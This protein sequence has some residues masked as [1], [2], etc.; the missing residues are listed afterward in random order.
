[1]CGLVMCISLA[2]KGA[3][4]FTR[5]LYDDLKQK[6]G[7]GA[8]VKL[9]NQAYKHLQFLS[10]IHRVWNGKHIWPVPLTTS[11]VTDA[12]DIGWGAQAADGQQA[13]GFWSQSTRN[14]H[15]MTRECYAVYYGLVTFKEQ[16]ANQV[17]DVVCDNS[18]VVHSLRVFSTRSQ[19]LM[20]VIG[21][22]FW[23]C[24]RHN[25]TMVPRLIASASN[26]VDTLSRRN[27]DGEWQVASWLFSWLQQQY[28]PHD[29]DR[30]ASH[31]TAM[32]PRYNSLF[33]DPTTEAVDA[34]AQDWGSDNNYA[35]P[36][37]SLV[38]RVVKKISRYRSVKCTLIVPDWPSKPW[39]L[40]LML[41]AKGVHVLPAGTLAFQRL[42]PKGEVV[43][44]KAKWPVLVV[45]VQR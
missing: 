31:T 26:V 17:V 36:P 13:H 10:K 32:L 3:H 30:F 11:L 14:L 16:Y 43:Q 19:E 7:W 5:C 9:S 2:F 29:V 27:A 35:H 45:R 33:N 15:I 21:L 42:S 22:L 37:F 44:L 24:H 1:M 41:M 12:S 18:A 4:Y 23:F 8:R 6:S 25:V 34:L 28:G 20:R 40:P 39:Y 38:G